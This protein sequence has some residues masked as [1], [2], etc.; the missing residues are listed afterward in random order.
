MAGQTTVNKNPAVGL[1][2]SPSDLATADGEGIISA[3]S[4][5]SSAEITRGLAVQTSITNSDYGAKLITATTNKL[6]G[7]AL[8]S[9]DASDTELGTT[10][11]K[12]GATFPVGRSGRYFVVIEENV[13][14]GQSVRIRCAGTGT[15]GAFRTTADATNCLDCT[16]FA[17]W[18]RTS[19]A[20]DG[21]GEVDIDFTNAALAVAG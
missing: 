20:A 2:G 16:P 17:K 9:N 7:I 13:A 11:W 5:E 6:L 19:L 12:P 3:N 18:V 15:A 1:P 8:R 21:V 14:P 10:G 4:E